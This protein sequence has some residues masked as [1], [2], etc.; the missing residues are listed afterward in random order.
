MPALWKGLYVTTLKDLIGVPL[1][2]RMP[3]EEEQ[4]NWPPQEEFPTWYLC[5]LF[6][7]SS[8]GEVVGY[9]HD[10]VLLG[11]NGEFVR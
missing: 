6:S 4:K 5:R 10:D 2:L 3:T 11:T 9:I 1:V 7:S 8:P